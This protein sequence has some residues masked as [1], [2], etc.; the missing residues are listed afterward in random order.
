[1]VGALVTQKAVQSWRDR[2]YTRGVVV[3]RRKSKH[4][5]C[6]TFTRHYEGPEGIDDFGE[7][8]NIRVYEVVASRRGPVDFQ[9]Y[10]GRLKKDK[11]AAT[12]C[13]RMHSR[14]RL[15]DMVQLQNLIPQADAQLPPATLKK[16]HRSRAYPVAETYFAT[17]DD[18]ALYSPRHWTEHEVGLFKVK[19]LESNNMVG[20]ASVSVELGTG[21]T[22]AQNQARK[23]KKNRK[24]KQR[25]QEQQRQAEEAEKAKKNAAAT[26]V[27]SKND[28]WTA[29]EIAR[30]KAMAEAG[31]DYVG[32]TSVM[33]ASNRLLKKAETVIS[34]RTSR[35]VLVLERSSKSHN[36]SA[37][38]RT[39]EALG[40]QH[41]YVQGDIQCA[42]SSF[43]VDVMYEC[44]L[45][46]C[47]VLHFALLHGGVD[48]F[49]A[50]PDVQMVCGPS[51]V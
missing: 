19:F 21:G 18:V 17:F 22:K 7:G 10:E 30:N 48:A 35:F 14:I 1:M 42:I 36:Y 16:L 37:C 31:F 12:A 11:E 13:V 44:K 28:N 43:C 32:D 39:A 26:A 15:G 29:A 51:V 9:H 20:D 40:V 25:E 50:F 24:K 38:L 41:V 45:S 3:R 6:I 8:G 34:R 27:S 5:T 4:F 46:G 2:K 47:A 49:F 23:E 33:E